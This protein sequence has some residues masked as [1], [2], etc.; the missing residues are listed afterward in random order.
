MNTMRDRILDMVNVTSFRSAALLAATAF[1][2]AACDVGSTAEPPEIATTGTVA[3]SVV[4]D[5]DGTRGASPGDIPLSDVIVRAAYRG[6]TTP[7]AIDTTDGSGSYAMVVPVGAYWMTVD[8]MILGDTFEVVEADTLTSEVLPNV[9]R[10]RVI[11]LGIRRETIES[12]RSLPVGRVVSVFG[13][14][15]ND[16]TVFGDSVIH[17]TDGDWSIRA[18]TVFRSPVRQGD[19]VRLAGTTAL[20]H[21]QPVLDRVTATILAFTGTPQAPLI[22]TGVAN[23]AQ[24]GRLDASHA[25]V[26]NALVVDTA[27]VNGEF[28]ATLND[29]SGSLIVE[30]DSDL[31]LNVG[32]FRPDSTMVQVR[33]LLVPTGTGTWVLKPRT[34]SDI[35]P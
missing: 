1:G 5:V 23:T 6:T 30:A 21:G 11:A 4:N 14:A 24:Q 18:T 33:G 2:V 8:S 10:S 15:L 25:R 7:I 34:Q 31:F 35:Q 12:I 22:S 19:S 13:F 9:T 3:G 16:R 17:L 29:G 28:R 20:D 26:R 32:V 27:T